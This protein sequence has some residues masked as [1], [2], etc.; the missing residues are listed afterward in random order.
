MDFSNE[1]DPIAVL[2]KNEETLTNIQRKIRNERLAN[3]TDIVLIG[4]FNNLVKT[5]S[6]SFLLSQQGMMESIG[7]ILRSQSEIF[8]TLI[9]ILK[10]KNVAESAEYFYNWSKFKNI[11]SAKLINKWEDKILDESQYKDFEKR[12][13]EGALG[14]IRK[15]QTEKGFDIY[16]S[17]NWLGFSRETNSVR[18]IFKYV[19]YEK[20]YF[21][22]YSPMS[23]MSHGTGVVENVKQYDGHKLEFKSMIGLRSMFRFQLEFLEDIR[24]IITKYYQL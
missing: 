1:I 24:E 4:L 5:T 13:L 20:F 15:Y 11:Q 6:D 2:R 18:K 10:N 9:Y 14:Y 8:I 3:E 22:L 23:S 19:G 17:N 7:P 16:R 21:I 12:Y